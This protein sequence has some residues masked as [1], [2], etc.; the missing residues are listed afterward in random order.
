MDHLVRE[1]ITPGKLRDWLEY[2]PSQNRAIAQQL[3]PA[4]QVPAEQ[5]FIGNGAIEVIQAI[6]HQ[7]V[8][9]RIAV[10]LPT[11]SSY[12]EFAT[13]GVEPVFYQLEAAQDFSLNVDD[14]L[15]WV[16]RQQPAA[17]VLI[18]PN[19]PS[20]TYLSIADVTRLIQ[21]L[22]HLESI[23]IDESFIH[24]AAD[25]D[26][27]ESIP[28]VAKLVADHPNLVVVK[29]L[30]K[31][32]G[33]AGIRAGYGVMAAERVSRLLQH[34]Y[35]WNSS[36][37]AEYFFRL[38]A[39]PDF[40]AAYAPVRQRYRQDFAAFQTVLAR[41][42]GLQ[43]FPSQANFVLLKLTSGLSAD[44]FFTQLLTDHG[45]YVRTC[46]DKRG[47]ENGEYVRV[48]GRTAEENTA[49]LSA[50]QAVLGNHSG[51]GLAG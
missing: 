41:I 34:G 21:S 5:I 28:S 42:P 20:G 37:L 24:F 19:N 45:I 26:A 36:G 7:F 1:V 18:N 17:V 12:Y 44:E 23:I 29:S 40:Q 30:S 10:N 47:L 9:G 14:Y 50:V 32:F 13:P 27:D 25:P 8:H 49:I 46:R 2:Y 48:A 51:R 39:R 15:A 22:R 6:L 38:Y 11:F 16:E 43:V 3:A 31:D 33:I 4:I 35:L